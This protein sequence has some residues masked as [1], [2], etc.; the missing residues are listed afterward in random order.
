MNRNLLLT[1]LI[2]AGSLAG[3]AS[4]QSTP[5]ATD[6][7]DRIENRL[8]NRGDRID[9]HFDALAAKQEALGHD[10]R[11]AFLE[12][13]GDRIQNRLDNRG[14]RINNRLDRRGARIDRHF[15]RRGH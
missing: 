11:A 15:D 14:E 5:P 10:K 13:K 9:N 7:G 1:A 8:D 3:I 6:R 2:A 4:A 12:K